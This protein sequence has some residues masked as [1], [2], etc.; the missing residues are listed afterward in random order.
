[1]DEKKKWFLDQIER[2][3]LNHS[4][5]AEEK[6]AYIQQY[7]YYEKNKTDEEQYVKALANDPEGYYGGENK[8]Y[9]IAARNAAA[10]DVV[11][12]DLI[13]LF[14]KQIYEAA[15][16]GHVIV[17]PKYFNFNDL[18]TEYTRR[19]TNVAYTIPQLDMKEITG[20]TDPMHVPGDSMKQTVNQQ[21]L[22]NYVANMSRF[23]DTKTLIN[24]FSLQNENSL[25]HK[26][27]GEKLL[28]DHE[29]VDYKIGKVM[30]D[31][32]NKIKGSKLYIKTFGYKPFG[33][34][35]SPKREEIEIMRALTVTVRDGTKKYMDNY[36]RS[37]RPVG[38][39]AIKFDDKNSEYSHEIYKKIKGYPG[40]GIY[41]K[42]SSMVKEINNE[43]VVSSEEVKRKIEEKIGMSLPKTYLDIIS[44]DEL[45]KRARNI[46][47]TKYPMITGQRYY[48]LSPIEPIHDLSPSGVVHEK[49]NLQR[50]I[51]TD[52]ET[53]LGSNNV[54]PEQIRE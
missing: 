47:L 19:I 12:T 44:K 39:F 8:Y 20:M 52:A 1:M 29:P 41:A 49:L 18:N 45:N 42:M 6:E 50:V 40:D 10:G 14:G 26:T 23:A 35:F 22:Q 24:F 7:D 37:Y 16:Q 31:L 25:V 32:S 5:T 54:E 13:Y 30:Y 46:G 2:L 4:I 17:L 43:G 27:G 38:D 3:Y 21:P 51:D 15:Q 34:G 33:L 53:N 11:R 48:S 9:A 36:V 28:L